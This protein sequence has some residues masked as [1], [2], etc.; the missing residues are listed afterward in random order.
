MKKKSCQ[1]LF[2]VSILL[3]LNGAGILFSLWSQLF[4]APKVGLFLLGG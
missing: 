2:W 1:V 4:G 3:V